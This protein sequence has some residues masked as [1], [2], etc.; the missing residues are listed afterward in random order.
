MSLI[1]SG[2]YSKVYSSVNN[3]N[4]VIKKVVL[5]KEDDEYDDPEI[6]YTTI[7]ELAFLSLFKH[8]N[9]VSKISQKIQGELP[10]YADIKLKHAGI[11]LYDFASTLSR[12][13]RGKHMTTIAFQLI[14][15]LY[16]LEINN[17][18]HG[19]IKPNNIMIDPKT[20]KVTLIDFGGCLFDASETESVI[21]CST[22]GFRP[23]EHLKGS[24]QAYLVNSKNDVFSFGLSMFAFYFDKAP[25]SSYVPK[26]SYDILAAFDKNMEDLCHFDCLDMM[27]ILLMC[28]RM[29]NEERPK[30][31]EL[32]KLKYFRDL[33]NQDDFCYTSVTVE[34]PPQN[35]TYAINEGF[36]THMTSILK[37]FCSEMKFQNFYVH[38]YM[39]LEKILS[40]VDLTEVDDAWLDYLPIFVTHISYLMFDNSKKSREEIF[41]EYEDYNI[42]FIDIVTRVLPILDFNVFMRI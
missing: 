3:D 41:Y 8:P 5:V 18:I 9:I 2:A 12:K 21:W 34:I 38:S 15:A 23:P 10:C 37:S 16:Y 31:S 40:F 4:T 19:D 28:I 20:L 7:R 17:V 13:Q 32:Y 30:A 1:A 14:K 29:N 33:R 6:E 26:D 11:D 39:L 22:K 25:K 27:N 35:E 42:H 36:K 24:S